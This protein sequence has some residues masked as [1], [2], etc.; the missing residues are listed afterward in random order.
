MIDKTYIITLFVVGTDKHES[1]SLN[2]S[3]NYLISNVF[4]SALYVFRIMNTVGLLKI[5][6]FI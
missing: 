6:S 1:S 3:E 5:F 2:L 4:S